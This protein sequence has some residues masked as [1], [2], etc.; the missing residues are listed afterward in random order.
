[1]RGMP[2]TPEEWRRPLMS[3]PDGTRLPGPITEAAC[4]RHAPLISPL[5]GEDRI[6][7]LHLS[8]SQIRSGRIG[9]AVRRDEVLR[10]SGRRL[11]FRAESARP[12]L[13]TDASGLVGDW[14]VPKLMELHHGVHTISDRPADLV[15]ELQPAV[16]IHGGDVGPL[17]PD[18]AHVEPPT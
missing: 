18:V 8:L 17:R 4:W 3:P 1:M 2:A 11:E 7:P 15:E 10:I 6:D 13:A 12:C 16:E 5:D 9:D 14:Q